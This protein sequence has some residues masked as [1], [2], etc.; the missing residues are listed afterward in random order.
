MLLGVSCQ[1]IDEH[2]R[3]LEDKVNKALGGQSASLPASRH[4]SVTDLSILNEEKK[5]QE[6]KEKL[7][8]QSP[9]KQATPVK[10][11]IVTGT[12]SSPHSPA[13]GSPRDSL[14]DITEQ[15]A[16]V[17][18]S[19]ESSII[20]SDSTVSLIS[21]ND[22]QHLK[23]TQP[24]MND[25]NALPVGG[26]KK[27]HHLS[28]FQNIRRRVSLQELPTNV[29]AHTPTNNPLNSIQATNDKPSDYGSKPKTS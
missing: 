26:H 24:A 6:I 18:N 9:T 5:L 19:L 8:E 15:V 13:N 28:A 2:Q 1:W 20:L 23:L 12:R 25:E 22:G 11:A 27:P 29:E 14:E 7:A 16:I 10:V 17:Q 4:N 21:I 3:L